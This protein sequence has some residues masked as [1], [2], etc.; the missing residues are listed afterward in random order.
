MSQVDNE[1]GSMESV[2]GS[3]AKPYAY[4]AAKMAVGTNTGVSWVMCKQDDAQ[5]PVINTCNG[6]YYDYFSPNKNSNHVDCGLDWLIFGQEATKILD[7]VEC[8]HNGAGKGKKMAPECAATG[9]EGFPTWIINGKIAMHDGTYGWDGTENGGGG[10]EHNGDD[11]DK[12]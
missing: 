6:F 4:W 9:L 3:D 7:Y 1:F 5:D 12:G 10:E 8:F 11:G 2:G